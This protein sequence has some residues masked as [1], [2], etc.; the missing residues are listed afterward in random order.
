MHFRQIGTDAAD[1]HEW[2]RRP[3]REQSRVTCETCDT[4][5]MSDLET[6][7]SSL[8]ERPISRI[9]T[10]FDHG[11]QMVLATW[12]VQTCL[13]LQASQT[14]E[15]IAPGSHFAELRV[16][17]RPPSQVAVWLAAHY[18]ARTDA[19]NSVFVQRPLRLEPLDDQL[20]PRGEFG[21]LN[22]LAV[23]GVA[24]AVVGHRYRNRT[25]ISYDGSLSEALIK[26]WPSES[27]VVWW[28]PS[29]MLDR[30]HIDVI[31]LPPGGFR[32]RI[33]PA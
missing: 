31:T 21:Y 20:L 33:W 29:Y 27:E 16:N 7:A 23:G 19:A 8:L 6:E 1:R 26:I 15:P 13:L 22:F 11:Q 4:G 10:Q 5:W 17:Q 2:R 32:A 24:F 3:F 25:D 30:E 14:D 9:A 28:P 18:R 12:A